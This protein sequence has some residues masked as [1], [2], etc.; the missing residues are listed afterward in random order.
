MLYLCTFIIHFMHKKL[1]NP[2]ENVS[3]ICLNMSTDFVC[4]DT[5]NTQDADHAMTIDEFSRTLADAN[6]HGH[7]NEI[8]ATLGGIDKILNDFVRISREYDSAELLNSN[9][10]QHISDLISNERT[11]TAE[12]TEQEQSHT[13]WDRM[14]A[15][16]KLKND[17]F[18]LSHSDTILHSIISNPHYADRLTTFLYSKYPVIAMMLTLMPLIIMFI[19]DASILYRTWFVVAVM[20][21]QI[22]VM[23]YLVLLTLSCNKAVLLLVMSGFDFWIKIGY[24][25]MAAVL[26]M[27]YF[28][29]AT[30][31]SETQIIFMDIGSVALILVIVMLSF[32]EGYAV[33][34]STSF[35]VGFI[36]SLN[37]SRAAVLLTLSPEQMGMGNNLNLELFAGYRFDVLDLLAS[38]LRVLSL[39]F[40][41]Q[42]LMTAY[43]RGDWCICIYLTPQIKWDAKPSTNAV[44]KDTK[45]SIAGFV[46]RSLEA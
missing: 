33:K 17:T 30:D 4:S 7:A 43:T 11:A 21:V 36:M 18:H 46:D 38:A 41:K 45:H 16:A 9:Q 26:F 8:V 31:Y 37:M 23:M 10:M 5:E 42:T 13:I 29:K 19:V 44:Q 3:L 40:W 2:K 24:G 34:W 20:T 15:M 22:P 28:R 35:V 6:F 14:Y 32:I 27:L 25:M 12:G 1:R 39:F